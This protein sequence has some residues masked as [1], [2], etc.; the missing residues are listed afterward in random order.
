MNWKNIATIVGS[1]F[2]GGAG[3]YASEAMGHG[4]PTTGAAA[5]TIAIGAIIAG[6]AA[7]WH[8][9]QPKPGSVAVSAQPPGAS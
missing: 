4:L 3:N 7:V 9:Y 6:A 2:L 8:L 5:K 1:A